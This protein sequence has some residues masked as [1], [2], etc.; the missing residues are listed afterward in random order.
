M[1]SKYVRELVEKA[2]YE[3][4]QVPHTADPCVDHAA[5]CEVWERAILAAVDRCAEYAEGYAAKHGRTR[6]GE[7]ETCDGIRDELRRVFAQS[8]EIQ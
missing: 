8:S 7:Q 1:A 6:R 2:L 3:C 4:M 5:R